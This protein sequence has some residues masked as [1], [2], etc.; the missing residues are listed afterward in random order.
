[1][2]GY[3]DP[4][5]LILPI[6]T[7]DAILNTKLLRNKV[8]LKGIAIGNGWIDPR[9]QYPAYGDFAYE[10]GFIKPGTKVSNVFDSCSYSNQLRTFE[11]Q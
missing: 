9:E 10:K 7:A 3:A 11:I 4:W 1:M 5:N 8:P 2:L 6:L